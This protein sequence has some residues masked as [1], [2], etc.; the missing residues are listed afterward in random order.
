MESLAAEKL[1]D[2]TVIENAQKVVRQ[3]DRASAVVR[4]LRALV[5][6]ARDDQAPVSPDRILV[7]V[8]ELM[9]SEFSRTNIE[10]RV[11]IE[12]NLPLLLVDRLQIEQA[13]LNLLRNAS[14]AV[15]MEGRGGG[16]VTLY[17]HQVAFTTIE[18]GVVDN[19]PGFP[20]DFS[21]DRLQPFTSSKEDGLGIGLSLCQLIARANSGELVVHRSATGAHVALSFESPG[22]PDR[23]ENT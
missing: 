1:Q 15:Q 8:A 20:P 12:P 13:L 11:D 5:K 18:L 9:K 22:R 3:I 23:D 6:L 10:L 17:A 4:R 19:G 14:E 2:P 16:S 7:E 21:F